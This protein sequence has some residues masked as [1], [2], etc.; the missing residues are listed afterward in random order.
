MR[1]FGSDLASKLILVSDGHYQ[2]RVRL[3][4]FVLEESAKGTSIQILDILY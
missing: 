4:S 3:N 1:T 2:L